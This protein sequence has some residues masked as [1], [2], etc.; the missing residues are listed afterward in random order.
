MLLPWKSFEKCLTMTVKYTILE[1]ASEECWLK[2]RVGWVVEGARLEIVCTWWAYPGFKSLTLRQKRAPNRKIRC[3]FSILLPDF[4]NN[5][6]VMIFFDSIL[7]S[8]HRFFLTASANVLMRKPAEN[9]ALD[10][11]PLSWLMT[12]QLQFGFQAIALPYP[13]WHPQPLRF[14]YH[15]S[16]LCYYKTVS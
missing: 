14:F 12:M 6:D 10:E 2:W 15:I 3:S 16:W 11:A 8:I 13:P 1:K 9:A 5:F 4:R 7:D